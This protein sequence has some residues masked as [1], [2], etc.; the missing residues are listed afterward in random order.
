VHLKTLTLKGFKSFASATTLH[1][2]PGVTAV[3][4]PN[5]SGKSNVVD[6]LAWVMGEQGAKSLRGGK[7]EDV[8]FAGTAGRPALGRA[9]VS[10]TIDNTDG[11]LPIEYTEVTISRIMFRSGGSE[12]A[13]NGTPCRLLDIQ[14]LLSDSGIGR[15]MHVIVGQGQLDSVL[16]ATPEDRRGFVEEAAGV[17]KHRKRK[18]KA[19]RKLDGLQ[20]KLSRLQDLSVELRRQ[21]KPLGRQAEVARR[22]VVIQSDVRD[23][24][25]RLLADD[26][27][28]ASA[29]LQRD[30][31]DE[32]A[33]LHK[34]AELEAQVLAAQSAEA[35]LTA[36]QEGG[37]PVA[38]ATEEVWRRLTS[39]VERLRGTARIAAERQ[40][41]AA[42]TPPPAQGRDPEQLRGQ[43]AALEA[44]FEALTARTDAAA[45]AVRDVVREREAVEAALGDARHANSQRR[46]AV[47]DARAA[48]ARATSRHAAAAA[49]VQARAGELE[50]AR[51]SAT[52]AASALASLLAEQAPDVGHEGAGHDLVALRAAA[53]EAKAERRRRAGEVAERRQVVQQ[54]QRDQAGASARAQTLAQSL[55]RSDANGGAGAVAE[56]VPGVLGGVA[57]LVGVAP[58]HRVAVAAVLGSLAE[59]LVLDS[60][61]AAVAALQLLRR[62]GVD[63]AEFLVAAGQEGVDAPAA[64]PPIGLPLADVVGRDSPA[65]AT[66]A[67]LLDR[68]AL[69]PDLPSAA[70][71]VA[72]GRGWTA[73]TPEG[74][75]L[76]AR[77]ARGGVR[78]GSSQ[79]ELRDA[80]RQAQLEADQA[81]DRLAGAQ[82]AL[83]AAAA[84]EQS[85]A[86]TLEG[87]QAH[88]A[89]ARAEEAARDERATQVQRRITAARTAAAGAD[90]RVASLEAALARHR[91]E[92]AAAQ[93]AVDAAGA[94]AEALGPAED[95]GR[96]QD[97]AED[98]ARLRQAE[99]EARLALR[100]VEER[101]SALQQRIS[102]L[103]HAARSQER[104]AATALQAYQRAQRRAAVAG[105]IRTVAEQ[106][107][108][109]AGADLERAAARRTELAEQA[110][111]QHVE[112]T[113][114][115][116]EL[117]RL[118]VEL[119]RVTDSVHRDEVARAEQRL[120]I[121]QIAEKA[122]GEFGISTEVLA[123]E[124][125]PDVP[126]PP[127]LVAPGDEEQ[128]G[129]REPYPYER[130]EQER[131]LKSAER[132]LSLLG[133]VNPLALEEFAALEER[134]TYLNEQIEDV[135]R[136]R[137]DLL[138]I[139]K[140]VDDRV[141][142]VFAEAF[143][144]TAEQFE[145]VFARLFPGGEGKLVLT[146]PDNLLT[147]GVEVEA[148][149]PG[150]KIKRLSLLSGGERS[151]TAV[152]FLI[153]LFKARPSPFY[154]L[155]EVEA[156][157]DDTNLGRL[158]EVIDELRTSSQLI[159]IT[160]QK[161][162]MEAAD[163]L[164]GVAMRGD[165]VTRVISQRLREL[166][167]SPDSTE[168]VIDL[169]QAPAAV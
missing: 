114:L 112:L 61:I 62:Q 33:L 130:R 98:L 37:A 85:A 165:G 5:G 8:I 73:V 119:A 36:D 156:A 116:A 12:Y 52:T 10:L 153:A 117:A 77:W 25:L 39:V 30:I 3:V 87:A 60:P 132:S 13:I 133:T 68:V 148:R 134:H 125:G 50:H 78:D 45:A 15:E 103:H 29:A 154:V 141:E 113:R 94:A 48:T 138:G 66:M 92:L 100:T 159:V 16:H 59:G 11:A 82:Q 44:E 7:M 26:F 18:E 129:G 145:R 21:L 101:G 107:L 96:E 93:A 163:A 90:S 24:R 155:D 64:A 6:A 128:P 84:A 54:A 20:D 83:T 166:P 115:R 131:R 157:L 143:R 74:D 121:E 147:T 127:S 17:L 31:A 91:E 106:G 104:A 161:R 136:S 76:A 40:A 28:A 53:E 81:R 22:A 1:L 111:Q 79:W 99:T 110:R 124:Y 56:Q 95:D 46:R 97:L 109:A 105:E 158:I 120:R 89:D 69:V 118:G 88:L 71:L 168:D 169:T 47:D 149:P 67:D 167:T 80:V 58:E 139:V 144:D 42:D 150:K 57:D 43:A 27:V 140:D 160:H 41:T 137:A 135:K 123:A 38:A 146:D 35:E 49:A 126:V 34:R 86:Q 102:G 2:E 19:L 162:T 75:V 152:A 70:D 122:L 14:E 108:A 51:T 63:R 65:A 9:E 4:G 164:Y 55:A 23:A 142:R 151:L 32:E 72:L